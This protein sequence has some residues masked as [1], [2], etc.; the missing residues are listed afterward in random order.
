MHKILKINLAAKQTA[1]SL[2]F[3]VFIRVPHS[4]SFVFLYVQQE[5]DKQNNTLVFAPRMHIY[6][7]TA[8]VC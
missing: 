6:T 8:I 7:A 4:S 5:E 3:I 2:I 1:V